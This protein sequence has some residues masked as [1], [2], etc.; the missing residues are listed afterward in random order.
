MAII[1]TID[2]PAFVSQFEKMQRTDQFS[3]KAKKIIFDYFS[4][5]DHDQELDIIGLCCAITEKTTSDI[6]SEYALDFYEDNDYEE[7]TRIARN[8]LI[9]NTCLLGEFETAGKQNVFVFFNF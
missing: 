9:D 4:E 6:I 7:M 2:F 3:N 8:Y 5:F 1:M